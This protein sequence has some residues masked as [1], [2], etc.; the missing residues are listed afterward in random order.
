MGVEDKNFNLEGIV[1]RSRDYGDNDRI[2][3]FLSIDRGKI[4]GIAKGVRKSQSS[5]K[6]AVQ[7]FTRSKLA[8]AVGRGSL[9]TITQG[10]VLTPFF[11]L[12]TDLTKIVY[13]SYLAELADY[14]TV[15]HK[16]APRIFGL[17]LAAYTLLENDIDPRLA[18]RAFELRFLQE[19]GFTPKLDGCVVCGR[20]VEYSRFFLSALRGGL[21]CEACA[22]SSNNS[23]SAGTVQIMKQLLDADLD[24]LLRLRFPDAGYD[25]LYTAITPYLDYHLDYSSRARRFLTSFSED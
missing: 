1:I 17:L 24:K 22:G 7:P 14:G 5:L 11:S 16:P 19:L 6:G 18:S 4:S 15:E 12:R 25:E 13:A 21:I 2:I 8:F 10:E 9:L 20:K 3:T 23:I